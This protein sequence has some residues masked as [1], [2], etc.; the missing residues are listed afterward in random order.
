VPFETVSQHRNHLTL[1]R[2]GN[3]TAAVDAIETYKR[4]DI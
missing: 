1:T 4:V 2:Q 3:I